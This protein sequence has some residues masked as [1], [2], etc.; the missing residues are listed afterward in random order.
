MERSLGTEAHRYLVSLLKEA[1]LAEGS[2]QAELAQRLGRQ[3]SFVAKYELGE[4]RLDV[5]E[6]LTICMALR[7]DS[8]EVIRRVE[9]HLQKDD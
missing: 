6:F 8:E 3:Q 5:V 1:R 7:V 4:R 2:T 9:S